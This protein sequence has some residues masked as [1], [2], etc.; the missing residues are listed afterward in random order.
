M[1][2]GRF[3]LSILKSF[4]VFFSAR[5]VITAR[6]IEVVEMRFGL[7]S[8]LVALSTALQ[9][10][11]IAPNTRINAPIMRLDFGQPEDEFAVAAEE[12]AAMTG[13]RANHLNDG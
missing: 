2:V 3:D 10:P 1:I 12:P 4:V 9:S 11:P 5:S 7:L 6:R 13:P 8:A